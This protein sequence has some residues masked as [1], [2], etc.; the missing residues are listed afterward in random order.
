MA[1]HSKWANIKRHKG[2]QD[3]IRG[4]IFTKLIKEI[5]VAARMGGTDDPDS[6]PRLRL[7]IDKAFAANMTKDTITRAA[8]RG[9][10]DLDAADMFEMVYEGY[11]PHGVAVV[12]ECLTDNKNR[13]AGDVRHAFSKFGGNMG[14]DGSV[15]YMFEKM[16]VITLKPGYEE[17]AV[18]EAALD[19]GAQEV[20]LEEDG[21]IIVQTSPENLLKAKQALEAA[22]FIVSDASTTRMADIRVALTE[23]QA[24]KLDKMLDMLEDNDDVQNVYTNA[25][26]PN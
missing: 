14:S 15:S 16:G 20:S 9:A 17:E 26:Y 19:A 6:N 21:C 5:T 13:T 18:F 10:G 7:A 12:V 22:H 24:E 23:E 25:D 4:K 1:G 2:K 11:A 8:K 3:A